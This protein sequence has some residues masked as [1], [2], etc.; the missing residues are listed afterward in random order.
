MPESSAARG[1]NLVSESPLFNSS[2][3]PLLANVTP[4]G[5]EENIELAHQFVHQFESDFGPHSNGTFQGALSF[6]DLMHNLTWI[7]PHLPERVNRVNEMPA[8]LPSLIYFPLLWYAAVPL[9]SRGPF[10]LAAVAVIFEEL[11]RHYSSEKFMNTNY[12]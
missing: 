10:P 6:I 9:P 11:H 8:R 12:S 4:F 5:L 2:S 7:A 3:A 1:P